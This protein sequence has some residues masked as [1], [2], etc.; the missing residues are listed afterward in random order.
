MYE[1]GE[2]NIYVYCTLID[3]TGPI[4]PAHCIRV[5]TLNVCGL[6]G[7]VWQFS[8]QVVD[9]EPPAEA[10]AI[11]LGSTGQIV[12]AVE[13]G[14]CLVEAVPSREVYHCLIVLA[15]YSCSTTLVQTYIHT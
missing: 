14:R 13:L 15:K 4:L 6:L 12:R 7:L 2:S 11:Q 9:L 8:Q 5:S 3:S 10:P 1:S